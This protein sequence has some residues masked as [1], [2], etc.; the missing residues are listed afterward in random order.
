MTA[1]APSRA[2]KQMAPSTTLLLAQADISAKLKFSA[3]STIQNFM[4]RSELLA[5]GMWLWT[6]ENVEMVSRLAASRM[7][8]MLVGTGSSFTSGSAVWASAC[9]MSCSFSWRFSE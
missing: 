6:R 9:S 1:D 2:V 5:G 8:V 3:R 4:S 7:A